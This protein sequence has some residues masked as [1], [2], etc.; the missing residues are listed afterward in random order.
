MNITHRLITKREGTTKDI[1]SLKKN[2]LIIR[3]SM[4][5]PNLIII[6]AEMSVIG[7]IITN[8]DLKEIIF[9]TTII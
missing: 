4:A 3:S 1:A 2:H 7:S 8:S 9:T 6:M 5:N